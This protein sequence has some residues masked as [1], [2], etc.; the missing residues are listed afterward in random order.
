[1]FRVRD[2]VN[3]FEDGAKLKTPSKIFPPLPMIRFCNV[4]VMQNF[5]HDIARQ[6]PINFSFLRV[7]LLEK[8]SL[9]FCIESGKTSLFR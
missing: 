1:M 3:F 2:L 8:I 9:M 7:N 4:Y 6:G 5:Y